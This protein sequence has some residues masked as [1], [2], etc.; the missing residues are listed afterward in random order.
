MRNGSIAF[1]IQQHLEPYGIQPY[2]LKFNSA[3]CYNR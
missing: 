2:S 1:F 3:V